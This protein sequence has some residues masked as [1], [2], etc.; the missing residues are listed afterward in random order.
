MRL[1]IRVVEIRQVEIESYGR[2]HL[3]HASADDGSGDPSGAIIDRVTDQ[4]QPQPLHSQSLRE[5]DADPDPLR[6]FAGW[7]RAAEAA[8][9]RMPEAAAVATATKAAVPS[10]RMV[11]IKQYDERGFQFFTN[12]ASHKADEL[13]ENPRAALLYYWDP[14]GR[15]VRIDGPVRRTTPEESAAYARSRPRASQI[16]AL[17]SAQSRPVADRATLERRVAEITSELGDDD[18]PIQNGWGGFL[19]TPESFEFWQNREDRLH[20]RLLYTPS[21]GGGWQIQR[22]SP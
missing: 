10:L 15:Q 1:D 3:T 16:S 9:V 22:L 11:L 17:A 21:D 4:P 12:Y 6:Q 5:A 7:Y 19:L 2:A 14:L 20:D 13:T 18:P 8:G